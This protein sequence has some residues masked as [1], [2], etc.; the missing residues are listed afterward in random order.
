MICLS[1]ATLYEG[2]IK[3]YKVFKTVPLLQF[4]HENIPK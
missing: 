2:Y 1:V 3:F 4:H